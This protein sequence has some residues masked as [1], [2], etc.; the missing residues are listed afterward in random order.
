MATSSVGTGGGKRSMY[1]IS[2]S[3]R[4]TLSILG[5]VAST[6]VTV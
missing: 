2:R 3:V 6:V 4:T 1:L 5:S